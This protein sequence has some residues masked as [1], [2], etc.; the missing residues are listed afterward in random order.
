MTIPILQTRHREVKLLAQGHT[1]D[2]WWSWD[3][4]LGCGALEPGLLV[5][6]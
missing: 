1:D 6:A 5:M 3:S 2:R 4:S